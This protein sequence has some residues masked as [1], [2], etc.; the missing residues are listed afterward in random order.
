MRHRFYKY[1]GLG[2]DFILFDLRDCP[3]HRQDLAARAEALCDRRFGVGGDGILLLLPD[4]HA[5]ARVEIY[6]ADGSRPEMCGNGVRCVARFLAE[7]GE[8]KAT[9]QLQTDAGRRE[10]RV[11]VDAQGAPSMVTVEMGAPELWAERVP[12][13]HEEAQAIEVPLDSLWVTAVSMGN[14]HAVIFEGFTESPLEAARRYGPQLETHPRFP[15][16]TNVEFARVN[17]DGSLEVA[18]WERG[19]GITLACGTGACATL[20]AA[21]LTKRLSAGV[22]VPVHVPGGT[23]FI[24]VLPELSNVLMRGPAQPVFVGEVELTAVSL[25][26]LLL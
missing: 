14:P 19:C 4:D 17:T 22:E 2:N 25:S 21:V 9:C 6:N 12:F 24:T 15:K 8:P 26:P 1:H 10:C 13:V 23:L 3:Q 5:D 11:S 20:V 18:I 16:K 7:H